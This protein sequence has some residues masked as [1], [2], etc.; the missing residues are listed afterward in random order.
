MVITDPPYN[1]PIDGHV[2]GAGSV[3]HREFA[4]ASGEM[5]SREF[6]E[7]LALT[8]KIA[9]RHSVDGS[10][11][12]VFIDWR[13]ASVLSDAAR[14]IYSELKNICIWNKTNAGM[15]SLYRSKHEFV[16]VYKLGKAPHINNIELGRHGRYRSNVWDY[17]GINSFGR[18]RD[19]LLALH[20][21]VKPVAL[22]ADAI[23]TARG[24]PASSS[25]HLPAPARS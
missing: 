3:T 18:E 23:R 15:G 9:A 17:G 19:A 22:L 4:M 21:T 16:F 11:H 13:H 8:L 6:Q 10:I 24:A 20:P 1:V 12:Y 7:F 2:G 14:P 5:S 25:I